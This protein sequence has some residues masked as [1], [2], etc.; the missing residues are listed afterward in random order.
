MRNIRDPGQ[1]T[2]KERA[3]DHTS[4]V[5]IVVCSVMGRGVH[6]P[7][8][9]LDAQDECHCGSGKGE[10]EAQEV[11]WVPSKESSEAH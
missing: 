7:H 6:A 9:R 3:H 2:V 11:T 5:Q 8:R 10:G 1:P 4:T